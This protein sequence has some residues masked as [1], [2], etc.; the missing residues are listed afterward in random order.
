MLSLIVALLVQAPNPDAE[1]DKLLAGIQT[2]MNDPIRN[3]EEIDRRFTAAKKLIDENP[4]FNRRDMIASWVVQMG[5]K[6]GRAADVLGL[7][8][9]RIKSKGADPRPLS[10]LY[11][12]ALRTAVL[13]MKS[14]EVVAILRAW[15]KE[16]PQSQFLQN[17]EKMEKDA[18][19]LGRSAPSVSAAPVEGTKFSWSSGT[20]EKIVILYFTASW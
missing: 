11:Y 12:E 9:D 1:A 4:T 10:S 2:L 8:K 16:E 6:C 5:W 14:E 3:A 7:A 20:R 18:A 15:A 19:L 13:A 17:R